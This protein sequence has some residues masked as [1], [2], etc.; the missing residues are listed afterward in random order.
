MSKKN[1]SPRTDLLTK[2]IGGAS[3][4][5]EYEANYNATKAG[6]YDPIST[7]VSPRMMC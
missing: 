6:T 4:I 3:C 2:V 7:V 5:D 1:F